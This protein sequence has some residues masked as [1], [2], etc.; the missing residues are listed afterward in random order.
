M[1]ISAISDIVITCPH[2]TRVFNET[3]HGEARPTQCPSCFSIV[4]S[5]AKKSLKRKK[6]PDFSRPTV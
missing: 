3:Q 4:S 2:C 1:A 6:M 5:P